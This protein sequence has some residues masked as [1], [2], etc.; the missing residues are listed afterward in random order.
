MVL[1]RSEAEGDPTGKGGGMKHLR[2]ANS[3]GPGELA[4]R[5]PLSALCYIFIDWGGCTRIDQCG[6][7]FADCEVDDICL[8]DY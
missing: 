5:Q 8:I 1:V 7:D 4:Q 3:S 6:F 2:V